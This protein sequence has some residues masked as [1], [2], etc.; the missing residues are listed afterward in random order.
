MSNIMLLNMDAALLQVTT[1]E[2]CKYH[3]N[4]VLRFVLNRYS[5]AKYRSLS[6]FCFVIYSTDFVLPNFDVL[7]YLLYLRPGKSYTTSSC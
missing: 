7:I 6:S 4:S 2:G 3:A 1:T 5:T